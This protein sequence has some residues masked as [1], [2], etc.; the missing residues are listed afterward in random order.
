MVSPLTESE[1]QA[2]QLESALDDLRWCVAAAA[3]E[4]FRA[5]D[6]VK[7]APSGETWRLACD[8]V[9]NEVMPAGWPETVAK[10]T[11]CRLTQRAS[12]AER[13]EMLSECA[14]WST[15]REDSQRQR[16]AKAQLEAMTEADRNVA[17]AVPSF[18]VNPTTGVWAEFFK[19]NPGD[20]VFLG[21]GSTV[22]PLILKGDGTILVRGE[23]VDNN[24]DIYEAFVGWLIEMKMIG[25]GTR[26]ARSHADTFPIEDPGPSRYDRSPEE[27]S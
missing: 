10:A 9:E 5:G 7:H 12:D 16:R 1:L 18:V 26:G 14:R 17:N 20:V 4:P 13:L 25:A 2:Y 19:D 27:G 3:I 24:R 11:H 22:A 21:H 23:V 6:R 8:Q 15:G